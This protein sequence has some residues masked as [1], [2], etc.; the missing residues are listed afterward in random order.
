MDH[1]VAMTAIKGAV[2]LGITAAMMIGKENMVVAV[3]ALRRG[4][5]LGV[6]LGAVLGVTRGVTRLDALGL[7]AALPTSRMVV[8]PTLVAVVRRVQPD[9][10]TISAVQ[11]TEPMT[12]ARA[13]DMARQSLLGI[14]L[15]L[16]LFVH[17]V[18]NI[19]LI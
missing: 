13:T 10:L 12:S 16:I 19:N 7:S 18:L 1:K 17:V 15:L 11:V 5:S 6:V 8:R 2:V 4:L 14:I 3:S 9:L